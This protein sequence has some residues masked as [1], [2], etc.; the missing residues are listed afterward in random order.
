[1]LTVMVRDNGTPSKLS[2][3]R[4][5]IRVSDENDHHPEFSAPTFE[6]QVYETA[7]L[8]SSVIRILAIDKDKGENSQLRFSIASGKKHIELNYSIFNQ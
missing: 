8:G 3:A 7:A 2:F 4:V 5:I 1:M 6:C